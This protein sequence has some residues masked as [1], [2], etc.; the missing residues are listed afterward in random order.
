MVRKN[1]LKLWA[2]QKQNLRTKIPE[3]KFKTTEQVS[4]RKSPTHK[5]KVVFGNNK[6]LLF[7][8]EQGLCCRKS[9]AVLGDV[10]PAFA[11]T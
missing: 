7:L 3:Q 11:K 5:C 4:E 6:D 9:A 8:F 1:G 2:L 10:R